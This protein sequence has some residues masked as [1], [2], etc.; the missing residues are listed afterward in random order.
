MV[1]LSA[2]SAGRRL[3]TLIARYERHRRGFAVW[4]SSSSTPANLS[5]LLSARRLRCQKYFP[6]MV[7][8]LNS[9]PGPGLSPKG[10]EIRR[11]LDGCE[12]EA[13][14]HPAIGPLTTALRRQAL[15]RLS[16]LVADPLQR[17]RAFV[18]WLGEKPVGS[19]ELFLGKEVA[20]VHSLHVS[21]EYE[22]QGIGSAMIDHA[23]SEAAQQGATQL[24]LLA[25][26]EGQLLYERRGF[27]EVGRLAY[28]YRSFQR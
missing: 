15:E 8:A 14:A 23:C 12:F 28:W 25:S 24:V 19:V 17:T 9:P 4:V 22:G 3:D 21:T 2:A 1:R 6:A 13:T 11:I 10:L 18:A 7:R 20:G 5:G 16:A 26:T 27:V